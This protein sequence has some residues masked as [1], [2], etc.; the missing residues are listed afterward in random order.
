MTEWSELEAQDDIF[1]VVLG[2]A[3]PAQWAVMEPLGLVIWGAWGAGFA[4][5][6]RWRAFVSR[7]LVAILAQTLYKLRVR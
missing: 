4:V 5:S 7:E 3:M 1:N 2:L 6:Q